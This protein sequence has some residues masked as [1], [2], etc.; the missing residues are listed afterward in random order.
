MLNRRHIRLKIVQYLYA[1]QASNFEDTK[2]QNNNLFKSLESVFNLFIFQI[3]FLL[4][5]QKIAKDKF[6]KSKKSLFGNVSLK[7][8]SDKLSKNKFLQKISN[9]KNLR[10]F[11][12]KKSLLTGMLI[13]NLQIVF[14]TTLLTVKFTLI[15]L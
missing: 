12:M 1:L 11:L 13:I 2:Q 7:Y 6:E 8:S 4:E 15:I 9:Q 3:S 14:I 10:K 5:I